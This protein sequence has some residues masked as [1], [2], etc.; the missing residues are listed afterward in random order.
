MQESEFY[1]RKTGLRKALAAAVV[2]FCLA[3]PLAACGKEEK[4]TEPPVVPQTETAA[5]T[6]VP[7]TRVAETV[8][9]ETEVKTAVTEEPET[10]PPAAESPD[11]ENFTGEWV[12]TNS[13]RCFMTITCGD[14][15]NYDIEITW[16]STASESSQW[17]FSG[18]YD[19]KEE[20]IVYSGK[21]LLVV[22]D[23]NGIRN[24]TVTYDDGKGVI[25]IGRNG[26]LYWE[27]HKEDM[28]ADCTFKRSEVL[29]T[30]EE[31]AYSVPFARDWYKT[32]TYFCSPDTGST[33]E[34]SYLDGGYMQVIVDGLTICTFRED[35]Y[36]DDANGA[37][38]YDDSMSGGQLR[39]YPGNH[40][41]LLYNGVSTRYNYIG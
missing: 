40:V 20:G 29:E 38:I 10:E 36:T 25:Y 32:Y 34:M 26:K 22:C 27:D 7:E 28:G 1:R 39:Y 37:Y 9:L 11:P 8:L 16:G 5:V 19:A 2:V 6:E 23:E 41:E 21:R 35:S 14:G 3:L 24:E 33:L 30:E 12:D 18:T 31:E 15:V 13:G 4:E 17:L